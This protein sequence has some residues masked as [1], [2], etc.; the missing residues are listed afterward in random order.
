MTG[1]SYVQTSVV[2]LSLDSFS[3]LNAD[4][5][6]FLRI[7][8]PKGLH[9]SLSRFLRPG[10]LQ[11][12]GSLRI[13]QDRILLLAFSIS[14]YTHTIILFAFKYFTIFSFKYF[15][16]KQTVLVSHERHI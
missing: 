3:N 5:Y 7:L 15:T 11:I 2:E 9:L 12:I 16:E 13:L 10:I 14:D 8:P 1:V 4:L 6:A